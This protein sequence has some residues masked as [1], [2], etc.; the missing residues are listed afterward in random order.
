MG[1]KNLPVKE[2]VAVAP[3]DVVEDF[4]LSYSVCGAP[5]VEGLCVQ[6]PA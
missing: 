5:G 3:A 4:V 6:A 2:R 1:A